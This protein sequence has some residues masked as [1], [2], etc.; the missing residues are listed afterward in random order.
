MIFSKFL[1]IILR[2]LP[3]TYKLLLLVNKKKITINVKNTVYL[4]NVNTKMAGVHF[5]MSYH[6]L[7]KELQLLLS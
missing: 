3:K 4:I 6:F 5:S 2:N 1:N 7:R